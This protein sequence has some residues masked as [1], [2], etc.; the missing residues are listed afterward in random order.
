VAVDI[1]SVEG[2]TAVCRAVPAGDALRFLVHNAA[3]GDPSPPGG[4]IDVDHFRHA[5]EARAVP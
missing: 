2:Q 1:A 3:V 4:R 5:M